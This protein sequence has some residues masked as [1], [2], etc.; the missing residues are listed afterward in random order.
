MPELGLELPPTAVGKDYLGAGFQVGP[1]PSG[2]GTQISW[3][4][5]LGMALGRRE[6]LELHLLG[7][8]IGIDPQDLAIKLPAIGSL[9]LRRIWDGL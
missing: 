7:A 8:T 9:G 3:G 6:G 4:G 5:V 2:S 1:T